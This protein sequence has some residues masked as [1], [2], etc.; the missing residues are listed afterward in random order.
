MNMNLNNNINNNLNASYNNLNEQ[1]RSSINSQNT[2][3]INLEFKP[4]NLQGPDLWTQIMN[5][6]N[7]I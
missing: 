3:N 4:E 6:N 5:D 2:S 7:E 1:S